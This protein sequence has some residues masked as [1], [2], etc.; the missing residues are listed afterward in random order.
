MS[1]AS[2][3]VKEVANRD[4]AL[5]KGTMSEDSVA[6]A[7]KFHLLTEFYLEQMIRLVLARGDKLI[8]SGNYSYAQKLGIVEA[9]D[10]VPD[11]L[12]SSLRNLNKLRNKCSHEMDYKISDSDLERIGSPLGKCWTELKKDKHTVR[13]RL[14][15]L[16]G[17]ISAYLSVELEDLELEFHGVGRAKTEDTELY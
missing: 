10:R 15:Y 13:A 7:L 6:T 1:V 4:Y 14:G 5:Y 12:L 9:S 11:N 16:C 8:D 17:H 2:K 3:S